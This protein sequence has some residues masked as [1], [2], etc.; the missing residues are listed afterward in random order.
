MDGLN[1]FFCNLLE[2]LM[3]AANAIANNL[4]PMPIYGDIY[5]TPEKG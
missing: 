1:K 5:K 3:D 2:A 4:L